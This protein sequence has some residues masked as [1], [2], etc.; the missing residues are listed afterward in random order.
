MGR[1]R[2]R[3][4]VLLEGLT[5]ATGV[6]D[7][8]MSTGR[9]HHFVAHH[10]MVRV[11]VMVPAMARALPEDESGKE[12][13]G[14]GEDDASDQDDPGRRLVDLRRTVVWLGNDDR[15]GVGDGDRN[16]CDRY[17]AP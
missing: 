15:G 17:E 6:T 13:N 12:N 10:V 4:G 16:L 8:R 11:V 2:R 9:A 5:G 1:D 7:L 3:W 14:R